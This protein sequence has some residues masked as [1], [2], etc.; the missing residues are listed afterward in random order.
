MTPIYQTPESVKQVKLDPP[1][2]TEEGKDIFVRLA[3]LEAKV[4][5]IALVMKGLVVLA[6]G[7]IVAY[8]FHN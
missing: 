4:R 6:V 5:L 2:L 7:E 3:V 8:M 1:K